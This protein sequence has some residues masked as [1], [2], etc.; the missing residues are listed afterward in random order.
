M[1]G[2]ALSSVAVNGDEAGHRYGNRGIGVGNKANR[3]P[4]A[5]GLV[6]PCG[7]APETCTAA[8][9]LSADCT[10]T[11]AVFYGQTS[12]CDCRLQQKNSDSISRCPF[13]DLIE[14]LIDQSAQQAAKSCRLPYLP[15]KGKC[16]RRQPNETRIQCIRLSKRL[17]FFKKNGKLK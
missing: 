4:R 10:V 17:L 9:Q 1:T 6:H 12:F 13:T 2:R 15:T 14:A 3:K 16:S 11:M 5:W 7:R 8:I